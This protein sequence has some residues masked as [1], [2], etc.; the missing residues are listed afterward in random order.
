MIIPER[1]I[2]VWTA[3]EVNRTFPGSIIWAPTTNEQAASEPW[4]LDVRTPKVLV[5]ESKGLGDRGVRISAAQIARLS[6]LEMSFANL[7]QHPIV[8]YGLPL[9]SG[10][11]ARS[12]SG[13][14]GSLLRAKFQRDF[15]TY[16]IMVSP[17]HLLSGIA[18]RLRG[19]HW[20]DIDYKDI[21]LGSQTL[22]DLLADVAK[23]LVGV[24]MSD[25]FTVGSV[26]RAVRQSIVGASDLLAEL[27][28]PPPG[29]ME[30]PGQLRPGPAER[31]RRSPE[32]LGPG[33]QPAPT[34]LFVPTTKEVVP[35]R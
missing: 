30:H 29:A 28:V 15:P 8:F 1:T 22:P 11:P 18:A 20:I 24:R 31:S 6:A 23:C 19:K 32:P 2:D 16:Q 7:A 34:F 9:G 5:F 25:D 13:K 17:S 21:P 26:Q 27:Q 12:T 14:P 4:D 33:M 10:R 35:R 3:L